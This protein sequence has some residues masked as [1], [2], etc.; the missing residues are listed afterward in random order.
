MRKTPQIAEPLCRARDAQTKLHHDR[1]EAP[2][3]AGMTD[4][5]SPPGVDSSCGGVS[6]RY[7]HLR[8]GG[9][10]SLSCFLTYD[11]SE[12]SA[13]LGASATFRVGRCPALT[14]QPP[15][16]SGTDAE[17][18]Q[19]FREQVL[20]VE[21]LR[22]CLC[23]SMTSRPRVRIPEERVDTCGEMLCIRCDDL[24]ARLT[25]EFRGVRRHVGQQDRKPD[26]QIRFELAGVGELRERT[27]VDV[28]RRYR[29]GRG[30]E[31]LEHLT[32][33]GDE[34]T[35]HDTVGEAFVDDPA[36]QPIE[37]LTPSDDLEDDYSPSDRISPTALISM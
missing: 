5:P 21:L 22:V 23:G 24:R 34:P 9:K 28:V 17:P 15:C 16:G 27:R 19:S 36:L 10:A 31:D 35:E 29:Q 3:S 13:V 6:V 7:T 37:D 32:E 11:P 1:S 8:Q 26:G 30:C 25:F 4:R 14:T 2:V 18:S 12:S 33:I 20:P